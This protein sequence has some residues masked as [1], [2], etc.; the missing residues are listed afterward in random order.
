[1]DALLLKLNDEQRQAVTHTEGPVLIVAGAGSGKTRVLTHRIAY[2]LQMERARPDQILAL[3]FTNKAAAEMRERISA[4]IDDT[5]STVWMG[6]FHSVF[7]KILRGE[8]DKIR[9]G[10]YSLSSGY[11]ILDTNASE[12]QIKLILEELKR[13]PK[14]FP[15]RMIRNAIS[16]AKNQL[17]G[18]AEYRLRSGDTTFQ[19]V[20]S[21]V[22]ERYAVE[23]IKMN[24]MDFDDL[25]VK[26]IDLF[27]DHPE[28][29]EKYQQKFRYILIDEYQDTNHAQY[30]VT[31]QLAGAHK[32]LCVVGDDAQSIYSFG[33]MRGW[34]RRF[35][36]TMRRASRS[37]CWRI[38]MSGTRQTGLHSILEMCST[39][40]GSS[41]TR[42]RFCF[43]QIIR[44]GCLRKRF[45][46]G[47]YPIRW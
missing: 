9:L 47:I 28:V 14:Q 11:S 17:I 33:M 34:R 26:P 10:E 45:G 39:A 31:K 19:R 44:V 29:L 3:T 21:D 6:T 38:S 13:D 2:L 22:Y 25:L 36:Q 18:P 12:S 4:L 23:L 15:P 30:V 43:A 42:W 1:M 40:M 46:V 32:N 7:S 37:F 41:S 27:R 20:I 5:A 8:A 16:T 35:G 24:S